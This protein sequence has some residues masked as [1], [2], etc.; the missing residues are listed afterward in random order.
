MEIMNQKKKFW[1][2]NRQACGVCSAFLQHGTSVERC[3]ATRSGKMISI[4]YKVLTLSKNAVSAFRVS[5]QV[6]RTAVRFVLLAAIMPF[7]STLA[8]A[9]Q[10]FLVACSTIHTFSFASSFVV[11]N[12]TKTTT[13]TLGSHLS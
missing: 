3:F 9:A 1:R 12:T 10:Y 11:S 13:H 5:L 7:F 4:V 8:A 2:G 6:H